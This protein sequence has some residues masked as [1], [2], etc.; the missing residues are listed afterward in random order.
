MRVSVGSAI[1]PRIAGMVAALWLCGT[2]S[3]WAGGSADTGGLQAVLDELCQALGTSCAIPLPS[4]PTITEQVLEIAGLS[5]TSPDTT[6]SRL[7]ICN[8]P[9]GPACSSLVVN[10]V[11]PPVLPPAFS[12]LTSAAA[13][14][15]ASNPSQICPLAFISSRTGKG[16]AVATQLG[17]H[18]ADT[19]VY[20]VTTIGTSGPTAGQPDKLTLVY[21]YLPRTL[22][23]FLKGR[24]LGRISLPLVELLIDPLSSERLVAAILEISA[25]CNGG[26][27]CLDASVVGDFTGSGTPQKLAPADLGLSFKA[28]F[29]ASPNSK[30]PHTIFEIDIP[31]LVNS[32]NDPP[33]YFSPGAA[34]TVTDPGFSFANASVGA[35]PDAAQFA[36]SFSSSVA[37]DEGDQLPFLLRPA[38]KAYL[39]I[40]INGAALAS[41]PLPQP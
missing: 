9:G 7:S 39:A 13:C 3:A 30:T 1:F 14:A 11:N 34:F 16:Q 37:E 22:P 21:D 12:K 18:A 40:G 5:N 38:V 2:G 17:K 25:N 6:R 4:L 15:S 26:P 32:V 41:A 35:A 28:L 29:A 31:L 8:F 36:A 23:F 24:V 33:Y 27:E 10:A 19:F 20:A